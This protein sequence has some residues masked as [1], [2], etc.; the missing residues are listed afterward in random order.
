MVALRARAQDAGSYSYITRST[1]NDGR[2]AVRSLAGCIGPYRIVGVGEH[3]IMNFGEGVVGGHK[4]SLR[5]CTLRS[6]EQKN[7]RLRP[8]DFV[9]DPAAG[10]LH[11]KVAPLLLEKEAATGHLLVDVAGQEHVSVLVLVVLVLFTVLDVVGEV[12]HFYS[13]S[14]F[15]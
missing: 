2:G 3:F 1:K 15:N 11:S 4:T 12:R 9:V 6:S 7:E 8:V 13:N 14:I 5:V 10:L